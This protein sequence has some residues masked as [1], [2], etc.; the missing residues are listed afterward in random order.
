MPSG[1]SSQLDSTEGAPLNNRWSH[2]RE[3]PRSIPDS[4][5]LLDTEEDTEDDELGRTVHSEL[6]SHDGIAFKD[7]AH[8]H[9]F[10]PHERVRN[11]RREACDNPH[12]VSSGLIDSINS[13]SSLSDASIDNERRTSTSTIAAGDGE[14]SLDSSMPLLPSM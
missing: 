11:D 7:V 12:E 3:V 13:L 1:S 5:D 10:S 6:E 9:E 4:V 2:W 8:E 14:C